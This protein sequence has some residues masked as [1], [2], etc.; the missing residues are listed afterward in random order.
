MFYTTVATLIRILSDKGFLEQTNCRAAVPVPAGAAPLKTCLAT[1]WAIWST[2]VFR[3]SREQ[4]LVRLLEERKLTAKERAPLESLSSR[5]PGEEKKG[6]ERH[7]NRPGVVHRADHA[8]GPAGRRAVSAG[9][10][11]ASGRRGAGG[12]QQSGDCRDPVAPRTKPLAAMDNRRHA[13]GADSVA[14]TNVLLQR[15]NGR[16]A[17]GTECSSEKRKPAKRIPPSTYSVPFRRCRRRQKTIATT[18]QRDGGGRR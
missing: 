15:K 3:G 13:A 12:V 8:A 17:R 14:S 5:R 2:G 9:A 11:I 18:G 10:A 4:L 7:W 6:H 1:W 16:G